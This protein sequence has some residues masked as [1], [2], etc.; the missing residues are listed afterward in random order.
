MSK[1]RRKARR[2]RK[3]AREN[4]KKFFL[5]FLVIVILLA[6]LV[7]MN[8]RWL[9]CRYIPTTSEIADLIGYEK[10]PQITVQQ[11]EISVHFIDVGQGDCILIDT[12]EKDMLIDCGET[13]Y[14]G[15]V[16][17]YL[18][19]FGVTKL[20]YVI[21]SHPHSDHMGGMSRIMT[22]FDVGEF[23][24]PQVPDDM[25]PQLEF[26]T[27]A[28]DVI[29]SKGIKLTYSEIGNSIPL[30]EGTQLDIIG[31]IGTGYSDL[32]S[33]SVVAKLTSGN[34]SFLFT[35]D[36]E[37]DAEYVMAGSWLTDLS[38]DVLKVPHHGSAS[39]SSV[40]F[41]MRVHP[42]YAV[43]S[44]GADNKYGHPNSEVVAFYRSIGCKT[45]MTMH[46]GDIVFITDG[47]EIRYA[48]A[49]EQHA[50]A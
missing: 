21:A 15:R 19:S 30:C 22:A 41:V 11:D 32:N 20:D 25:I 34:R 37:K 8:E 47:N 43:F 4:A 5:W 45:L 14:A 50:A 31:P 2:K 28:M 16:I 18:R 39:S 6:V 33:Y 48:T 35:G 24:M 3:Q 29:S 23:I 36:M 44:V 12:P 9:H 26:Y 49:N 7:I 27:D 38:A 46:S 13:E 42:E 40:E 1:K 17:M 10:R